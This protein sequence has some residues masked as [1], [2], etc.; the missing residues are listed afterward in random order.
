MVEP[1][2]RLVFRLQDLVRGRHG[3]LVPLRESGVPPDGAEDDVLED[4]LEG[5]HGPAHEEREGQVAVLAEGELER[6][7]PLVQQGPRH[8]RRQPELLVPEGRRHRV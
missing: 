8:V 2:P 4:E 1:P 5:E 7:S 6:G 3:P